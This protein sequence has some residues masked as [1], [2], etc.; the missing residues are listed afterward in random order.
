ME[1]HLSTAPF[2]RPTLTLARVAS[3]PIAHPP[4]KP[5]RKRTVIRHICAERSHIEVSE[6]SLVTRDALLSCPPET[7]LTGDPLNYKISSRTHA[8]APTTLRRQRG[9]QDDSGPIVHHDSPNGKHFTPKGRE[10]E[11]PL[12]LGFDLSPI[13][14]RARVFALSPEGVCA[15]ERAHTLVRE[16]ITTPFSLWRGIIFLGDAPRPI[17]A[18]T[19][20]QRGKNRLPFAPVRRAGHKLAF[21]SRTLLKIFGRSYSRSRREAG[22]SV[23]ACSRFGFGLRKCD[24]SLSCDGTP[25]KFRRQHPGETGPCRVSLIPPSPAKQFFAASTCCAEE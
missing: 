20:E 21:P 3:Q 14:G 2:G 19:G 8:M 13:I 12:A 1:V 4:E 9:F 11:V 17:D 15:E 16:L 18:S 5:G 7:A 25:M 24:S 6:Q 10:A 22:Q 23:L